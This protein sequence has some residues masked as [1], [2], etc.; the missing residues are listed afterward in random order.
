MPK[1]PWPGSGFSW[2]NLKFK[3]RKDN[4]ITQQGTYKSDGTVSPFFG[5]DWYLGEA[6]N[7]I[8]NVEGS[9]VND[10][11]VSLSVAYRF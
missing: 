10:E 2:A 4:R 1:D 11:E 8:I 7:L 5:L 9:F 3:V 6:E